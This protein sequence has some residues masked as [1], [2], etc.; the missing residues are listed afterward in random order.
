MPG[1]AVGQ[2][3]DGE[4]VVGRAFAVAQ[5]AVVLA[6]IV[7]NLP[8]AVIGDEL[9]G[10]GQIS[11][12]ERHR[13]GSQAAPVAEAAAGRRHHVAVEPIGIGQPQRTRRGEITFLRPVGAF[14]HRHL[15]HEFGDQEVDV[16]I[17]LAVP[18]G[19][20]V[21]RHAVE[22]EG[23]VGAV[24]EIHAAQE[25]LIGFAFAAVLGDDQAGRG[26]E[27]FARPLDRPRVQR[28]TGDALLA[29]CIGRF[30]L[31]GARRGHGDGGQDGRGA[32]AGA[33]WIGAEARV[34]SWVRLC[35]GAA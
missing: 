17:A 6:Q 31:E 19:A 7:G 13:P 27:H 4:A 30:R 35:P 1:I 22:P 9:G 23:K 25:V 15:F 16:G 28:F 14:P 33:E 2:R 12:A 11:L 24:V 18:V 34:G 32:R 21:D 5:E 29:R 26:L 8:G 3:R 10:A 20:H